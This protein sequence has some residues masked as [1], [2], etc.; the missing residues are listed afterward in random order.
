MSKVNIEFVEN[1]Y[2]VTGLFNE[3]DYFSYVSTTMDGALDIVRELLSE[4]WTTDVSDL[5]DKII[6]KG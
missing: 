5:V 4:A 3:D 2:I 6:P 1:G